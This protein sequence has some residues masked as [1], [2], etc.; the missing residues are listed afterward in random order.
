MGPI[1]LIPLALVGFKEDNASNSEILMSVSVEF[2]TGSSSRDGILNGLCVKT[3]WRNTLN[4]DV[5][6]HQKMVSRQYSAVFV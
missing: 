1:L 2:G 4:R 5:F 3:E 6:H